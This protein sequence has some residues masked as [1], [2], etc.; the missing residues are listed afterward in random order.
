MSNSSC[1]KLNSVSP[2]SSTVLGLWQPC[3]AEQKSFRQ[4]RRHS[5]QTGHICILSFPLE[6][7]KSGRCNLIVPILTY[8]QNLHQ[9]CNYR[10]QIPN[11]EFKLLYKQ[12][13]WPAFPW[14]AWLLGQYRIGS[15]S[16][17]T[18]VSLS[19]FLLPP[20]QEIIETPW[21]FWLWNSAMDILQTGLTTCP[22]SAL[23]LFWY[24][25]LSFKLF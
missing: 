7:L 24:Q 5:F 1:Q 19:L 17:I 9:F 13:C 3:W 22:E 18:S 12:M 20:C 4:V 8:L 25:C 16:S 6:S 15:C 11:N 2:E 21:K 10:R 23:L 14:T